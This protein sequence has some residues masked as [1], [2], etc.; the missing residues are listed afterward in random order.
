M[1]LLPVSTSLAD[2]L[3]LSKHD[4]PVTGSDEEKQ[5]IQLYYSG[6]VGSISNVAQTA[7][8]D[9]ALSA[10]LLPRFH[11]LLGQAH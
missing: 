10:H 9:L 8:P 5:L 2:K 3:T 1:N 11:N 6:L 7:R 4:S